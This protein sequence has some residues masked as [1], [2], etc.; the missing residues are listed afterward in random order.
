MD[1]L[2]FLRILFKRKWIII[3]LSFLAVVITLLFKLTQDRL[4]VSK[5]Q[6]STG[7]TI[8]RVKLSGESSVANLYTADTKFSNVIE[9]FKS[10]KVIGMISYKL[11]AHDLENPSNAWF[12]LTDRDKESKAYKAI[13]PDTVIAILNERI[14]ENELLRS[15][16]KEERRILDLLK[17]YKYDYQSLLQQLRIERVNKTDF[18]DIL[19]YS[20]NPYLCAWVVNAMGNEFLNY[21]KNLNFQRTNENI[22]NIRQMESEQQ[23]RIDSLNNRLLSERISQ[24]SV[25][26]VS[27]S[28]S[29]METVKDL[30]NSYATE[31]SKFDLDSNRA[32]FL[33]RQL[34]EVQNTDLTSNTELLDLIDKKTDL[35]AQLIASGGTDEKIRQELRTIRNKITENSGNTTNKIRTNDKIADIQNKLNEAVASMNAARSTMEEYDRKIAYYQGLTRLNPG[36]GIKMEVI[37]NQLDIEQKTLANLK[38]KLNQAEGLSKDDPSANFTQTLVGQ[39]PVEPQ[40]RKIPMSMGIAGFS[41]FFL[42]S[43]IF[44]FMEVFNSAIRTPYGFMKNVKLPLR[45]IINSIKLREG[46]LSAVLVGDEVLKKRKAEYSLFKNS[47]RKL[48]YELTN[49]GKKVF[50]FTSTERGTGKSF[51]IESLAISMLLLKKRVLLVDFNLHNNTLTS[52]FNADFSIQKLSQQVNPDL[53]SNIQKYISKTDFDQVFVIGCEETDETPTEVLFRFNFD[54]LI[55]QLKEE[56]DF[57]FIESSALNKFSDTREITKYTDAVVAVFSA[58]QILTQA[59]QTSIQYLRDLGSKNFGA[60]LNNVISDNLNY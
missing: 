2:Y 13:S 5:A 38:E 16:I 45:G 60:V 25:D 8:D 31:K 24:G 47:V 40:S 29:A 52:R 27:V 32:V 39:P 3:G 21:Y 4:Y 7:F 50:L 58:E 1:L 48:R 10:P 18:L 56:F 55:N 49:S 46:I 53:P 30:E 54:R 28:A 35:E 9:T 22:F 51:L 42:T 12:H 19:F 33:R 20:E 41:V 57:I 11:L 14:N 59:D 6:Y 36:S 37:K 44:L 17:L 26:P 43:F 23:S 15:D 34:R